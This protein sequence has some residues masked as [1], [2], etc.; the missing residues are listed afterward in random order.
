MTRPESL[1]CPNCGGAVMSDKTNCQF[2]SSRLKTV[3]CA[4]CHNHKFDPISQKEYYAI[5][6][7]FAGVKHGERAMRVPLT[8]PQLD[9]MR[10]LKDRIAHV[11]V[12]DNPGRNEPGTGEINYPFVFAALERLGYDGWVGCEYKPKATTTNGLGWMK[13]YLSGGA[14]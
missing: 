2:C 4:K 1:N 9:E 11:K 12:A 10:R 8:E 3:G 14:Q 7:V 6:A 5:Q 13:D